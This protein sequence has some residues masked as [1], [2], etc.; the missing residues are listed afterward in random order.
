ML[1]YLID[2]E[3][4]SLT[5]NEC[6]R[7]VKEKFPDGKLPPSVE[8]YYLKSDSIILQDFYDVFGMPCSSIKRLTAICFLYT[9][10]HLTYFQALNDLEF[11]SE[12]YATFQIFRNEYS[13]LLAFCERIARLCVH[14]T[15]FC[16]WVMSLKFPTCDII[17]AHMFNYC[18]ENDMQP[19]FHLTHDEFIPSLIHEANYKS[20]K[21]RQ[22]MFCNLPLHSEIMMETMNM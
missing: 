20:D 8:D 9:E 15:N 16:Y 4:L 10:D 3:N 18:V 14:D 11:M 6:Y 22:W 1:R 5:C 21:M 12:L 19:P 7:I 17:L 13:L 2:L